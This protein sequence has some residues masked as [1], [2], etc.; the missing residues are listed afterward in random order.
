MQFE[1]NAGQVE[2]QVQFFSRGQGYAL[3]LAKT[4]AVLSLRAGSIIGGPGNT[5]PA[6]GLPKGGQGGKLSQSLAGADLEMTLVGANPQARVEGLE[7]LPGTINYFVG[8]DPK[9]WRTG[10]PAFGKVK[11]SQVYPA[12]DLVYYG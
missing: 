4:Q 8:S 10:V 3:W 12:I 2:A 9:C 5:V 11:Y 6:S 1:A 7:R